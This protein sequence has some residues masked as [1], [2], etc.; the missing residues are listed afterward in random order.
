MFDDE[1]DDFYKNDDSVSSNS[2]TPTRSKEEQK[3]YN[4]AWYSCLWH[5]ERRPRTESELRT[6]LKIRKK[7]PEHIIDATMVRLKEAGYVDDAEFARGFVYSKREYDRLGKSSIRLKLRQK[8][9]P[10]DIIEEALADIDSDDEFESALILGRK[11]WVY[12]RRE[13]DFV[14]KKAKFFNFLAY[15]GYGYGVAND[16]LSRVLEEA[17]EETGENG[18][19]VVE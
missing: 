3:L 2:D 13:T 15:R 8:G 6:N 11:R 18:E 10:A 16:V 1:E 12:L 14:K 4:S 9:V 17:E 7:I 19:D 5:L